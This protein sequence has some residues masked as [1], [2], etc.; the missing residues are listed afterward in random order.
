MNFL[1]VRSMNAS[2]RSPRATRA[3]ANLALVSESMRACIEHVQI[4]IFRQYVNR[5][6]SI[7][8][9]ERFVQR[10]RAQPASAI[11]TYFCDGTK[12]SITALRI[13]SGGNI[14]F[15]IPTSLEPLFK[16][17]AALQEHS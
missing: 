3:A 2:N 7:T 9:L 16:R 1:P 10:E 12:S 4:V 6:D 5:T 11:K 8:A 17:R 14:D 15:C 13:R